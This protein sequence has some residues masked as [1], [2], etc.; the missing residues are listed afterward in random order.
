MTYHDYNKT[1]LTWKT[2]AFSAMILTIALLI[3]HFLPEDS[4]GADVSRG[5]PQAQ[6]PQEIGV[7]GADIREEYSVSLKTAA[8]TFAEKKDSALTLYRTNSSR[9]AVEWFFAHITEDTATAQAILHYADLNDIPPTLAFALA[10][11]ESRYK[12][13]AV[14][15]NGTGSVDRG[16]FQLNSES[17]PRL[18][19]EDF[20]DPRTNAKYGL[21]H[22]RFCLNSAG[23]EIAALAMY[24][25][26]TNRVK[27]D[28]AP[29]LTLRYVSNI[30]NYRRTLDEL[31]RQEVEVFFDT[32]EKPLLAYAEE[33]PT[34]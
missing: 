6:A 1:I 21:A 18:G 22:L 17:F 34:P 5:N 11:T 9:P 25:A 8:K 26:G 3:G 19:V 28:G 27:K 2:F 7:D 13:R 15:L 20:F 12:T 10:Y 24:N 4:G 31:F 29:N 14:H 30:T 33:H 16:L 32:A 23:N